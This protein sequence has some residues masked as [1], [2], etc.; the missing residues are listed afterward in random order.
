MWDCWDEGPS[1]ALM[2]SMSPGYNYQHCSND[3]VWNCFGNVNVHRLRFLHPSPKMTCQPGQPVYPRPGDQLR[4]LASW[5]ETELLPI[6]DLYFST[7]TSVQFFL[8]TSKILAWFLG[9]LP[10]LPL[11]KLSNSFQQL[12][13]S[14]RPDVLSSPRPHIWWLDGR[15]HCL[16]RCADFSRSSQRH[17]LYIEGKKDWRESRGPSLQT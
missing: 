3:Y 5:G 9:C 4:I 17:V 11:R 13:D 16:S 10:L 12:S 8:W 15:L 7:S 14:S 1:N 6:C 2:T